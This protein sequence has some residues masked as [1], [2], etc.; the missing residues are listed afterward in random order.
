M[1]YLDN[2]ATTFPKPK[3]VLHAMINAQSCYANPGRGGHMLSVRAG[4]LIF[5]VREKLA[6]KF[7]TDSDRIIF[8]K[9]CTESLN[10]AI[11]GIVKSGDHVI[12][13]SL[14]H[15]SVLRPIVKLCHEEKISYD[16]AYVDP[17][18]EDETVENFKRI[19]KP[20]TAVIICTHVSNV[21]GT[22][23]PIERIGRLADENKIK[24]VVDAAQSAGTIPI[25]MKKNHINV[26]CMPGHKG[27]FGPLGT[28]ILLFDSDTELDSFIEGGTGSFSME[29]NQP[30]IYPDKLE[31][32]TSNLPGIAGIGAGIDFI[33]SCGGEKAIFEHE[34]YLISVLKEDLYSIENLTV[35]DNMHGAEY[36]PVLSFGIDGMHSEAAAEML[37]E[38]NFAVRAGYHCS[39]HAHNTYNTAQNGTV[40][41]SPGYFNCKK[42]IKSLAFYLNKIA[43]E[44]KIC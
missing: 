24:F 33:E 11:K 36:A 43:N 39:F 28:G 40:R 21:F 7:G 18:N 25:D 34:K 27:L 22:I 13:S 4:H 23:L 30:L 9:N 32:G 2:A 16:V 19:I 3:C 8:T 35:Y 31:S 10:I 37:D 44:T 12:I 14:E 1:I 15:N 20:Q 38:M 29:M 41:V 42:N 5:T 6:E 26:L 17:Q